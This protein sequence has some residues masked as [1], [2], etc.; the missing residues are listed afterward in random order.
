MAGAIIRYALETNA[1]LPPEL[2]RRAD[3]GETLL[4]EA[5]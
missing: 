1:P 3:A 5:G 2:V 4:D